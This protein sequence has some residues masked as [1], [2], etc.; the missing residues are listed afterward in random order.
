[1]SDTCCAEYQAEIDSLRS[2]LTAVEERAERLFDEKAV[3]I[4]NA[5]KAWDDKRAAESALATTRSALE[6][7]TALADRVQDY[8][9][10]DLVDAF[11]APEL[12]DLIDAFRESNAPL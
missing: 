4:R 1:M 3:V 2:Q 8:I 5:A 9:W 11:V 7:A 10:N 6:R 12:Q